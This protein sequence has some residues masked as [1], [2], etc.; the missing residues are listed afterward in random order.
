MLINKNL[1]EKTDLVILQA[2]R[3]IA[4]IKNRQG[5]LEKNTA[6]AKALYE[7]AYRILF[8]MK[9]DLQ[10]SLIDDT[11]FPHFLLT[12]SDFAYT[13][14][15]LHKCSQAYDIYE[16]LYK[17]IIKSVL[18]LSDE[19]SFRYEWSVEDYNSIVQSETYQRILKVSPK[20]LNILKIK[21]DI[22]NELTCL[23]D[24]KQK[25]LPSKESQD[26]ETKSIEVFQ[27]F[28]SAL[29]IY[30]EVYKIKEADKKF[31]QDIV[32][33]MRAI[34]YIHNRLGRLLS[35]G[36]NQ[37]KLKCALF[38]YGKALEKHYEAEEIMAQEKWG[39]HPAVLVIR[40]DIIKV[41]RNI[42][43]THNKLG[44]LKQS[45]NTEEALQYHII[46]LTIYE[47]LFYIQGKI[48]CEEHE[49][50][51]NN[52]SDIACTNNYLAKL[53]LQ[54]NPEEALKHYKE[55]M[56]KYEKVFEIQKKTLGEKHN[57]TEKTGENLERTKV[58]MNALYQRIQQTQ[59]SSAGVGK[60]TL[61]PCH[62]PPKKRMKLP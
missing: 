11:L 2:R 16:T 24:S 54:D 15:L 52:M 5:E 35:N 3:S 1:A 53:N 43:Y 58:W 37:E 4:K 40:Q 42:A 26:Y 50:T 10:G 59:A 39:T 34:A 61:P 25:P 30:E 18:N 46:A 56:E 33:T 23:A 17:E 60:R 19:N 9:N 27:N 29:K 57:K 32:K 48:L 51:L 14:H 36:L 44:G 21:S 20:Y 55:A 38:H 62:I 41:L 31:V 22:A 6:S 45:S 12:L 8:S 28:Q 13:H 47:E 7:N 49:Y